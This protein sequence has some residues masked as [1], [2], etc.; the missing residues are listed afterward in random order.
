MIPNPNSLQTLDTHTLYTIIDVN[1]YVRNRYCR[2][3]R[4]KL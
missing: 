4:P 2:N 1:V 3:L